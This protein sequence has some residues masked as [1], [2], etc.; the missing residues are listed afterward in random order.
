[1][2]TM[3][4]QWCCRAV[5]AHQHLVYTSTASTSLARHDAEDEHWQ[6]GRPRQSV[7][8]GVRGAGSLMHGRPPVPGRP[9]PAPC[10]ATSTSSSRHRA[11]RRR[12]SGKGWRRHWR[13]QSTS[14]PEAFQAA[15]QSARIDL[16]LVDQIARRQPTKAL[17]AG[18]CRRL[19]SGAQA[20]RTT[21][22]GSRRTR[23]HTSRGLSKGEAS[24]T[25][26]QHGVR[27]ARHRKHLRDRNEPGGDAVTTPGSVSA[28]SARPGVLGDA[29]AVDPQGL[30][31]GGLDNAGSRQPS[32]AQGFWVIADQH[33]TGAAPTHGET[34]ENKGSGRPSAPGHSRRRPHTQERQPGRGRRPG[35]P[36]ERPC[37]HLLDV[38]EP[39]RTF[40]CRPGAICMPSSRAVDSRLATRRAPG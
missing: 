10:T 7:G 39:A 30:G 37:A 29:I 4:A 3:S 17:R 38:G 16:V 25:A 14:S 13:D 26:L 6:P 18:R 22:P 31:S 34:P 33:Q 21:T 35:R 19:R 28:S 9:P 27:Q 1:M 15:S 24:G 11:A 2:A 32:V 5:D 40:R 20:S 23:R 36:A 8:P 12:S